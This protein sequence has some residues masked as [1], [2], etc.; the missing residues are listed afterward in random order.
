MR[1]QTIRPAM[2][3]S[4]SEEEKPRRVE[5]RTYRGPHKKLKRTSKFLDSSSSEDEESGR[6][7]KSSKTVGSEKID[8]DLSDNAGSSLGHEDREES[9]HD[10]SLSDSEPEGK[11]THHRLNLTIFNQK[12]FSIKKKVTFY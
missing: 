2:E 5:K 4:D 10:L 12:R 6:K 1:S 7:T 8:S 9:K 11:Q 3:S